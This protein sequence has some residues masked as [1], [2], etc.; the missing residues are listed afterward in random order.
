MSLYCKPQLLPDTLGCRD[1][2]LPLLKHSS[3][4]QV[5]LQQFAWTEAE[6]PAKLADRCEHM[7][8][9][10]SAASLDEEPMFCIETALKALYWSTLVYRYDENAPELTRDKP[11]KVTRLESNK[12]LPC[13][14]PIPVT[15]QNACPSLNR[16]PEYV[17]TRSLLM[18]GGLGGQLEPTEVE[19]SSTVTEDAGADGTI[20]G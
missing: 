17:V 20:T 10:D 8:N 16:M 12:P 19:C 6:K 1:L 9:P 13:S 7:T 15:H 4:V 5:W 18:I 2:E 11:L 14:C 3:C